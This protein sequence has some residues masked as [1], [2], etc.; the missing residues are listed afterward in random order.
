[1]PRLAPRRPGWIETI[2]GPM[3]SGK[4]DELIR[5]L[6]L[7]A[8]GYRYVAAFKPD[9]DSRFSETKIVSRTGAAIESH[10][11]DLE[12]AEAIL[13]K[14]NWGSYEVIGFDEAQFFGPYLIDI[15]NELADA[16]K[17][18]VVAGLDTDYEGKPFETVMGLVCTSEYVDKLLAVC[19]SCG[20]PAS[21]TYRTV[22]S[23]TGRIAVGDSELYEARCRFCLKENT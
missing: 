17:R 10:P 15:C 4:S 19:V 18:V 3:F 11:L 7:A 14:T 9:I 2:I 12:D 20:E 13:K 6:N 16:G 22:K 5:R 23:V 8:I 21:R 1:M